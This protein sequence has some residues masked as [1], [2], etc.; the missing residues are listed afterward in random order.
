MARVNPQAYPGGMDASLVLSQNRF[1]LVNG[2]RVILPALYELAAR[3]ASRGALKVI[4]GGNTFN[5]YPVA[6][7]LRRLG[8]SPYPALRRV[9]SARAFTC[10]QMHALVCAPEPPEQPVLA[11]DFLATFADEAV[12]VGERMRLF[13]DCVE[14]LRRMASRQP[15]LV[16]AAQHSGLGD[17]WTPLLSRLEAA[18]DIHWAWSAPP[19]S[20]RQLELF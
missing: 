12:P 3:L 7:A 14:G 2:P 8:G 11:L 19:P 17:L 6:A 4:D 15:V 18:A 16:W 13:G 1:Y 10:Y 20:V 5:T 9:M